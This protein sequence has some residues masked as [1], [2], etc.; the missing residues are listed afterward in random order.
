MARLGFSRRRDFQLSNIL[1]VAA[2]DI[3]GMA[4]AFPVGVGLALCLGVITTFLA[5]PT[6]Q[7]RLML[8]AG[9][10]SAS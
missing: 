2:I 10:G 3:A 9:R 5:T 4:V 6:G 7:S 1:L 8:G